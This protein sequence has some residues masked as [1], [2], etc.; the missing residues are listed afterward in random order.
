MILIL[1]WKKILSEIC[2]KCQQFKFW[3]IFFLKFAT[4]FSCSNFENSV[5]T[6]F[7]LAHSVAYSWI[8]RKH[9]QIVF[10]YKISLPLINL[11]LLLFSFRAF[12]GKKNIDRKFCQNAFCSSQSIFIADSAEIGNEKNLQEYWQLANLIY[13]YF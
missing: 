5:V 2:N 11:N 13:S 1:H 10:F 6:D 8:Q 7:P 12:F 9:L 4:N 3:K